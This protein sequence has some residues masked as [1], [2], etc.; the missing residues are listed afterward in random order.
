M[1]TVLLIARL[2]VGLAFA[3]HGAQKLFGWFGGHGLK[4][5][6]GFF[7]SLGFRSGMLFAPA[8]AL[9]EFV[10]GVLVAIEFLGPIGPALLITVMVVAIGTVHWKNGFFAP[11]GF[12]LNGAY[13]AIALI[14]AFTGFGA[15]ALD[16]AIGFAALAEPNVAAIAVAAGI[17]LGMLN[18]FARRAPAPS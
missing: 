4:G 5:T 7:E 14:L 17:L 15:Y 8:A 3:A 16:A 2:I 13:I 11:N 18:L 9:A 10:G 1:D 6:A 12:E